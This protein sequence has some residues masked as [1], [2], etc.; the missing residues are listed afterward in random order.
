MISRTPLAL[1]TATLLALGFASAAHAQDAGVT[2]SGAGLIVENSGGSYTGAVAVDSGT[3]NL[4]TGGTLTGP[5]SIGLGGVITVNSG[6]LSFNLGNTSPQ[7]SS[8]GLTINS[9]SSTLI[10][11]G[12]LSLGTGELK[13]IVTIP[14]FASIPDMTFPTVREGALAQLG[15]TYIPLRGTST[16]TLAAAAVPEPTSY[17]MGVVAAV[18]FFVL[19]RRGF[20][21]GR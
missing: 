14:A 1:V 6:G 11:T 8:T 9:E 7:V 3:L 2:L 13:L 5:T 19:R 4:G 12:T 18:A 16:G 21:G 10:N 15:N 20:A 17:L